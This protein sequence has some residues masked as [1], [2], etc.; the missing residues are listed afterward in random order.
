MFA[1]IA[2]LQWGN[3][4]KNLHNTKLDLNSSNKLKKV[5]Q[6]NT[7]KIQIKRKVFEGLTLFSHYFHRQK[8][9]KVIKWKITLDMILV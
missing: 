5:A 3:V 4:V 1:L 8:L 6:I 7:I 9:N 2:F